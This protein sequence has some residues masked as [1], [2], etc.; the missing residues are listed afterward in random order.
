MPTV[1]KRPR[2]NKNVPIIIGICT[3]AIFYLFM[4][5]SQYIFGH[6]SYRLDLNAKDLGNQTLWVDTWS[7]AKK[8]KKMEI[9][10]AIEG[11]YTISTYD[12]NVKCMTST[13]SEDIPASIVLQDK[14]LLIIHMSDIPNR[15]S[16]IRLTVQNQDGHVQFYDNKDD[17]ANVENIEIKTLTSYRIEQRTKQLQH[18][19]AAIDQLSSQ[20]GDN[21]TSIQNIKS[22]I[23][24][25]ET[26]KKYMTAQQMK[27]A[28]THIKSLENEIS[29]LEKQNE[30][31]QS[32]IKEYEARNI[33][34]QREIND[35]QKE[36]LK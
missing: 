11:A 19:L 27:G 4:F 35:M 28:A 2:E 16:E 5:A 3:I 31:W 13:G 1:D 29:Q 21:S 30:T 14:D 23:L 33:N 34:L 12:I 7:Y 9:V 22:E 8:E 6:N 15:Y 17:I 10:V 18:N 26:Q 24:D 32:E 36:K 20:I 25:I